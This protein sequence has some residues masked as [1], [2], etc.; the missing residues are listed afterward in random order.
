LLLSLA[1][2]GHLFGAANEDAGINA[3]C[4]ADQAEHHNCA[5]ADAAGATRSHAAAIFNALASR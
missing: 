3:Q 4:P 2:V 1:A 5:D